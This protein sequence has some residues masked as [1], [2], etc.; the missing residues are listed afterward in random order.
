MCVG[1]RIRHLS[2]GLVTRE[3]ACGEVRT[4]LV[5]DLD[6]DVRAPGGLVGVGETIGEVRLVPAAERVAAGVV[7]AIPCD[8]GLAGPLDERLVALVG[9]VPARVGQVRVS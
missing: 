1:P 3:S 5:S 2:P 4:Q 8:A 7:P 6:G 9:V